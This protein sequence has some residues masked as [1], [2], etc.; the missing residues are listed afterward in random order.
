MKLLFESRG[1]RQMAATGLSAVEELLIYYEAILFR[2]L[3]L[4]GAATDDARRSES[5]S[6]QSRVWFTMRMVGLFDWP[7]RPQGEEKRFVW[8]EREVLDRQSGKR[9]HIREVID[10]DSGE[11]NFCDDLSPLDRRQ[12][13]IDLGGIEGCIALLY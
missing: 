3:R 2:Q 1:S 10:H 9:Y 5:D 7:N 11:F 6:L 4:H 13:V 8:I 12:A